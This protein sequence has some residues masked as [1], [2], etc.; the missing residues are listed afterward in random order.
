M[1]NPLSSSEPWSHVAIGYKKN[2]QAFL[3]PYSLKAIEIIN[4]QL[5][6]YVLDVATGPGTLSLP[7][8]KIVKR[9]E[10]IDFAESMIEQLKGGIQ[11]EKIENIFPHLMDGQN[12]QFPDQTFDLA[13]SM[14]G[15]MFFPDKMK[16]LKEIYRVLKPGGKIAISSWAPVADSNMMQLVFGALREA[17]PEIP[18]AQENI[19]S[20]E[21]RDYFLS[22]LK[23]AGFS[24]IEVI[25][26]SPEYEVKDPDE[27]YHSMVEGN[28][29]IQWMKKSMPEEVWKQKN[30][31]M[32][33]YVR[34]EWKLLPSKLTSK[35]WIGIGRKA[36]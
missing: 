15:L 22:Q 28:A 2:T 36:S 19:A 26:F 18:P 35:A 25:P 14:F 11:K 8:S 12:L 34:R 24:E 31:I 16:G 20:L 13:F 5:G 3:E 4:P 32:L 30:E 17:V 21:N 27:F 10:A 1:S 6:D 7:L 29:P 23:E 9:I 33:G